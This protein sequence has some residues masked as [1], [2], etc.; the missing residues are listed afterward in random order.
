MLF[1]I[2]RAIKRQVKRILGISDKI[3]IN[4]APFSDN[5][6]KQF[7]EIFDEWQSTNLITSYFINESNSQ[8][9]VR[10]KNPNMLKMIQSMFEVTLK[11][12]AMKKKFNE[13]IG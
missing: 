6:R 10:S 12:Y 4:C 7:I 2:F 8:I 1:T 5:I 11:N 3:I 13:V 9:S